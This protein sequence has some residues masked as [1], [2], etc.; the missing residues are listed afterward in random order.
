VYVR[1]VVCDTGL[2]AF[3]RIG[4]KKCSLLTGVL[5]GIYTRKPALRATNLPE[6]NDF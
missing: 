5:I 3:V 6:L 4:K 1:A 2:K